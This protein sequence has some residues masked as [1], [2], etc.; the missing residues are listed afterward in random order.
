MVTVP[1]IPRSSTHEVVDAAREITPTSDE[2]KSSLYD[3]ANIEAALVALHQD[4]FVVLKSVVD[5][6]HVENL[7]KAM[8]KEADY[9]VKNKV[10]AFNQG[11]N[12]ELG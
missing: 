2:L 4:G 10:K 1:I 8:S 11:V 3:S 5:V 12:C 7:S 9:L 6:A